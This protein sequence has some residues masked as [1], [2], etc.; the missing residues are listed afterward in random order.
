MKTISKNVGIVAL[1]LVAVSLSGTFALADDFQGTQL[2]K[3]SGGIYGHLEAKVIDENGN[4][5]Q[6]TQTDNRIVT[7]GTDTLVVNS[8]APSGGFTGGITTTL[9]PSTYMQIGTSGAADTSTTQVLLG[10]VGGCVPVTFTGVAANGL[11]NG[12][13]AESIATLSATFSGAGACAT[14][15]NEAGLFDGSTGSGTDNMFA[16]GVFGSSVTLAVTDSLDVDWTFT[17]TDT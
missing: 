7:N 10:P 13:F 3:Q 17:F 14:T 6:Y 12:G 8:F 16:R 15:F 4:V 1:A 9:G 5:K 2:E 11:D